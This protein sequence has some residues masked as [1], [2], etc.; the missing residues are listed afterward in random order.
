MRFFFAA[1]LMLVAS[2]C[3]PPEP[4]VDLSRDYDIETV[5]G[6]IQDRGHIVIGISD[7]AYP[8]GYVDQ[9]DEAQGFTADL[10][11]Y[12]AKILKVEAR[13]VTGTSQ[14]LL[15]LPQQDVVDI[16]FPAVTMTEEIVRKHQFSDPYYVA[17]QRLLISTT[18]PA[19]ESL[20]DLAGKNVCSFANEETQISLTSAEPSIEEI[21]ADPQQCL[22]L[23][24]EQEVHAVT[25]SDF[26]LA[27]LQ[28]TDPAR[29]SVVGEELTTEGI[30][31][32]IQRG[33]AGW[34][35]YVNGVLY[36]AEQEGVWQ[37]AFDNSIG[38]GLTEEVEPPTITAEEAAALYPADL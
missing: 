6:E 23:I 32:V 20:D 30:G 25:G 29:L 9:N 19:I 13:F 2:A 26:L 4:E 11:R 7:D 24:A 16:A 3:V 33:S 10:G 5:M 18:P 15:E 31:A 27:G 12:L 22:A 1:W 34:T 21:D 37:E 14:Q 35:D 28:V 38:Q 8:L 36:Q 17:H